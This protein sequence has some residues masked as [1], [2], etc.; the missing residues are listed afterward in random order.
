MV[1]CF[2][3]LPANT[4]EQSEKIR[5]ESNYFMQNKE[6]MQYQDFRK[7]GLFVGSGVVEAACKNIIGKRLK[8]SGMR[9]SVDGA[10][11]IAALRC[12]VMNGEFEP[13]YQTTA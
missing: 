1:A 12:A 6:R 3:K 5:I 9:W 11:K 7:Q 10:N 4:E 8:Q 2:A 13:I